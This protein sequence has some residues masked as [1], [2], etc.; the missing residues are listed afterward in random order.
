M[1]KLFLHKNSKVCFTHLTVAW[2]WKWFL[3]KKSTA[4]KFHRMIA[5]TFLPSLPLPLTIMCNVVL[6]ETCIV[7]LIFVFYWSDEGC[8]FYEFP[9]F[10]N[11]TVHVFWKLC[12]P[13]L[14]EK[15]VYVLA[16]VTYCSS[17]LSIQ[18]SEMK[19]SIY[20]KLKTWCEK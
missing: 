2:N 1:Q 9:V 11:S 15:F 20:W 7:Q 16:S 6:S 3:L 14:T 13:Q 8:G 12:L 18:T 19:V 10:R 4:F 5:H 17:S